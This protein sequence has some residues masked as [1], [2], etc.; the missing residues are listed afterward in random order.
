MLTRT[1]II[2]TSESFAASLV[3]LADQV[4]YAARSAD[5]AALRPWSEEAERLGIS[6]SELAEI[7]DF[8]VLALPGI[9][10]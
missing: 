9:V 4:A 8:A 6:P 1:V 3:T 5:P 10:V 7:A 2:P